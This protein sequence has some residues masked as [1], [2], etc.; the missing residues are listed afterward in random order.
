[1]EEA[2]G[3][4]VVAKRLRWVG[5]VARMEDPRIPKKLLFGWLP[6]KRPTH[7][8]KLQWRDR[9]RKD[10]K[11][12][13][14]DEDSCFHVAQDRGHWRAVCKEGL[15]TCTEDRMM[16]KSE[17]CNPPAP[18]GPSAHAALLLMC[19][20]CSRSF[21]RKQDFSRQKSITTHPHRSKRSDPASAVSAQSANSVKSGRRASP[22]YLGGFLFKVKGSR[23]VCVYVYVYV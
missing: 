3:D 21:R 7:G 6:Q 17:G 15:A 23:C 19:S 5:H 20:T 13:G 4:V 1:M 16:K 14:I 2:L 12:F 11:H 22:T 9:V 8:T 10:L 18:A